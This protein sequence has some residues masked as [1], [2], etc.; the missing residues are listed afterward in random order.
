M[1]ILRLTAIMWVLVVGLG[2]IMDVKMMI[3]VLIRIGMVV[4]RA[5]FHWGGGRPK[6][7]QSGRAIEEHGSV[8]WRKSVDKLRRRHHHK[9][10]GGRGERTQAIVEIVELGSA[11]AHKDRRKQ[12]VNGEK[13]GCKS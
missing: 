6:L 4:G 11:S 12:G 7:G 13:R 2:T 9:G 8:A 10:C 5:L 3:G 1:G